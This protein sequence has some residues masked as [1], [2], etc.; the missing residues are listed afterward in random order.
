MPMFKPWALEVFLW[1]KKQIILEGQKNT[2]GR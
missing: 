2:L 1:P